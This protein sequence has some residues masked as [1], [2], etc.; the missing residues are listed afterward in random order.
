MQHKSQIYLTKSIKEFS[1]DIV[2]STTEEIFQ[3]IRK[4]IYET[5]K[6]VSLDEQYEK[7]IRWKR[8]ADQILDDKIVDTKRGCTDITILFIAVAKAKNIKCD[9][10]KLRSKD[11]KLIHSI[12]RTK[13]DGEYFL[14]DVTKGNF[15]KE[16]D[17]KILQ[18]FD[19]VKVGKD[20]WDIGLSKFGDKLISN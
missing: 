13:I 1:N 10:V 19:I 9:F 5:V 4:K 17:S 18:N 11:G 14:F 8:T 15:D 16:K 6:L 7:E 3:N 12:I 2:G 20:S